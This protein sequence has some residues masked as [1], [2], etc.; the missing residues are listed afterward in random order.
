MLLA[1]IAMKMM[2]VE[3]VQVYLFLN[4]LSIF[5]GG[6]GTAGTARGCN[7]SKA[8]TEEDYEDYL[9]ETSGMTNNKYEKAGGTGC[10]SICS[11]GN[12]G[13]SEH[14]PSI[15]IGNGGSPCECVQCEVFIFL[16]RNFN[17]KVCMAENWWRM[18]AYQNTL[19]QQQER[20]ASGETGGFEIQ[21]NPRA[22]SAAGGLGLIG[23]GL[24]HLFQLFKES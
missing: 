6:E 1:I 24:F 18:A 16:N 12:D 3:M 21:E 8:E 2:N 13:N 17:L 23:S 7:D 15:N 4:T 5:I 11:D 10:E 9:L 19:L 20:G 22:A 14:I